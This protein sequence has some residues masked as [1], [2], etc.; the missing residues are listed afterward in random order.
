MREGA[1]AEDREPLRALAAG[2]AP[3]LTPSSSVRACH[4]D[5]GAAVG[6]G[7]ARGAW[8]SPASSLSATAATVA[9]GERVGEEAGDRAAA[10]LR[11]GRLG[12]LGESC[13]I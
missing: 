7:S 2:C 13:C 12:A 8:V 9:A 6:G 3:A 10:A 5:H 1:A 11:E 4:R